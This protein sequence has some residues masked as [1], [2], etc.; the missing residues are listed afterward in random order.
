MLNDREL[1]FGD[2]KFP[3]GNINIASPISG[4]K[5]AFSDSEHNYLVKGS[6]R[7]NPLKYVLMF[8]RLETNMKIKSNDNYYRL[9]VDEK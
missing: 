2:I 9:E 6:E 7:F 4:T 5:L 3:I 1:V 8:N